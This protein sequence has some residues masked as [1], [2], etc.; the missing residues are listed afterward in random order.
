[1]KITE[2]KQLDSI[3][4]LTLYYYQNLHAKCYFNETEM[5]I[6]SMNLYEFSERNNREMGLLIKKTEDSEIFNDTVNETH[7]I[8]QAA[9]EVLNGK[10]LKKKSETTSIPAK[11]I[12]P[13]T[14]SNLEIISEQFNKSYHHCKVNCTPTY[15]Y[16]QELLPFG[17][18]MIREGFEVRLHQ[19]LYSENLLLTKLKGLNLKYLNYEYE[20]INVAKDS[21]S[22]MKFTIV[23]KN[24]TDIDSLIVDFEKIYKRIITA[25]KSVSY[26]ARLM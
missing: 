17:D 1:M 25:T 19:N 6:T 24:A 15:V 22:K 16:C 13:L 11:C 7:S 9:T 8:I 21:F 18:V 26:K 12:F 10:S 5:V 14:K 4:N 3:E 23:S 20:I 2:R